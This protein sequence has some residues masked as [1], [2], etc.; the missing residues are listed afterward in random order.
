MSHIIRKL[1]CKHC[2]EEYEDLLISFG[3]PEEPFEWEWRCEECRGLN[4]EQIPKL[5]Q[6]DDF[7][8]GGLVA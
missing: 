1:T 2:Q 6:F 8:K 3:H 4:K 7:F 5:M